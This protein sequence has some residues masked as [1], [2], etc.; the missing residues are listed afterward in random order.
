MFDS[1]WTYLNCEKTCNGNE[2]S[3]HSNGNKQL[4]GTFSKGK[5]DILTT[6]REDGTIKQREFYV[7]GRMQYTKIEYYN[8]QGNLETYELHKNS[9]RKTKIRIFNSN[10][11]LI[12]ERIETHIIEK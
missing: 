2:I 5:P 10:D 7:S 3:Y 1:F 12:E 4:E 8:E 6:Y 9:K 11:K